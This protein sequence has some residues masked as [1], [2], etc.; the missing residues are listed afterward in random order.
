M[1]KK[2]DISKLEADAPRAMKP[3]KSKKITAVLT[4]PAPVEPV[5]AK[6][7]KTA[8]KKTARKTT[9]PAFTPDDVALR[10]YFIAEKRHK[11]GIPGDSH[12]D[13]L[14]AER[15]LIAENGKKKKP[16]KSE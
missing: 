15:Q 7:A 16:V 11:L 5:A 9:K 1:G 13:W 2:S 4:E 14:E 10:A 6:P 8:A 3:K 12:Q